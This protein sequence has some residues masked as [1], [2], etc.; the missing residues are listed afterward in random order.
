M[1]SLQGL[2]N[3]TTPEHTRWHEL[4]PN[5][6]EDWNIT[7]WEDTG[8]PIGKLSQCD[9]I[10]MTHE[11]IGE[12]EWFHVDRVTITLRLMSYPGLVEEK[13]IEF[14]GSYDHAVLLEPLLTSW[15]GVHPDYGRIYNITALTSGGELPE[16]DIG[17]LI[18]L[19]DLETRQETWWRA[20]DVATGLFFNGPPNVSFVSPENKP[21]HTEDVP[22]TFTVSES[23]S[24]IG[25]S[26]DGQTNVTISGNTTIIGLSDGV[27]TIIVYA[28]D[29]A[30]NVGHSN[31]VYFT[32]DTVPPIIDILSL[33]NKTYTSSSV[34]L[35]FIV[36]EPTSWIGYSLDRQAN[37]TIPGNTTLSGLSNGSH[38][39][40]LY[41]QDIAGNTGASE[42]IHFSIIAEQ[43]QPFSLEGLV[44]AT[45]IVVAGITLVLLYR[46]RKSS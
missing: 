4:Y 5:Y 17:D 25:Y 18:G 36:N 12:T 14:K 11:D 33:E 40:T 29:I 22:L 45:I 31:M 46:K 10:N 21:Y 38:K 39:I 20:E 43:A 41:A 42:T 16:L 1:H 28:K 8:E 44:I 24:W 9:Q 3:L 6:G 30:G 37:V 27:H 35:D 15:S 19:T 2:I 32:V 13:Y 34:S 26:L 23:T 7:N